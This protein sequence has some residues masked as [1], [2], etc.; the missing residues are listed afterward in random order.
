MAE[1]GAHIE[2][3]ARVL[4]GQ[5]ESRGVTRRGGGRQSVPVA[6]QMISPARLVRGD[7]EKHGFSGQGPG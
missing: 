2:P 5:V 3:S 1:I 6:G 7:D 4:H